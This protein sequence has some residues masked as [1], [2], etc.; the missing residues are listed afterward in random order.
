MP[1]SIDRA[2][3]DRDFPFQYAV[4]ERLLAKGKRL[5]GEEWNVDSF[6]RKLNPVEFDTLLTIMFVCSWDN[7]GRFI[8]TVKWYEESFEQVD[9]A[10]R[11]LGFNTASVLMPRALELHAL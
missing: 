6:E 2:K 11:R 3:F 5:T 4:Y 8:D 1:L 9:R 7:N 10:F